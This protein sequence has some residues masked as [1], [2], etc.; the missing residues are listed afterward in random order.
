MQLRNALPILGS[1]EDGPNL[2]TFAGALAAMAACYCALNGALAAALTFALWAHVADSFDGLLARRQPGRT[3][4]MQQIGKQMDSHADF[5]AGSGFPLIFLIV[6]G[7]GDPIALAGGFLLC[8]AGLLRLSYFNVHGLKD[9]AFLGLP[10]PHNILVLTATYWASLLVAPQA[11]PVLVGSAAILTAFLH[12]APFP[13]PKMN[14][15][16]VVVTL[17][18]ALGLSLATF[19]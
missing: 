19:L 7:K 13:F 3:P 4:E 17:I 10:L 16:A 14:M 11:Q 2:M 8:A 18:L 12:V 6:L 5:L 15:G 9:G 1:L